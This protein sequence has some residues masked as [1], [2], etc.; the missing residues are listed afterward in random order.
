M[1]TESPTDTQRRSLRVPYVVEVTLASEH[2]FWT[3]FTENLSEGG[4]FL[5]TPREV[6]VGTQVQFELRLPTGVKTWQVRGEVRW[7]RAADA[8][9]TGSP[10]G[11]GVQFVDL[12]PALE[13]EIVEFL[14]GGGQSMF[15]DAEDQ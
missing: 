10:P 8:V 3:G 11:V 1:L 13:A 6:A 14:T 15:F 2:N 7:V 9:D 4:V 5:A 12:D